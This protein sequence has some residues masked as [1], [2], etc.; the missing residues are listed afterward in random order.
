VVES[1]GIGFLA[2][3]LRACVNFAHE[4]HKKRSFVNGLVEIRR[5][6]IVL[7]T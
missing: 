1:R 6:L 5:L 3:R 2:S 4:N 7:A